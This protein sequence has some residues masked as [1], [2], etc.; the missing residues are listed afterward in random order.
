MANH[1]QNLG[2]F[3]RLEFIPTSHLET[4]RLCIDT[5]SYEAPCIDTMSC[6]ECG[7]HLIQSELEKYFKLQD[8]GLDTNYK[9]PKCRNCDACKK[10]SGHE[11]LS[12]KEEFQQQVIEDSVEIDDQLGQAIAYLA[13]ISNPA[14]TLGDNEHIAI[15][16][17]HNVCRKYSGLPQVKSMIIKGVQKLID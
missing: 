11:L 7:A 12:M 4:Q 16:R 14:E 10:G 6:K 2:N 13:I 15:K 5:M 17:L 8:A 1:S 9:C 3:K